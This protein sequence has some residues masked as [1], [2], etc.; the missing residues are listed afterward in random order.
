[1]E[2]VNQE[3]SG[4]QVNLVFVLSWVGFFSGRMN[5]FTCFQVAV[6]GL[7]TEDLKTELKCLLKLVGYKSSWMGAFLSGREKGKNKIFP[8]C[9]IPVLLK[10]AQICV[11]QSS[12]TASLLLFEY[13]LFK[14]I[15]S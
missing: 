4:F 14:H 5:I 9:S 10:A 7:R 1:M 2:G 8:Y 12:S 3:G 15:T 13:L 6:F 11:P